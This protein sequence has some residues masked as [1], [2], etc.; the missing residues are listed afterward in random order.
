MTTT[1]VLF[2]GGSGSVGRQAV[3]WFRQRYPT[4]PVLVGGRD[5]RAAAEVAR[6]AGAAE[7]VVIDLSHP[8]MGLG[9]D[10]SVAAVVMLAP[11]AQLKA[12]RY[13]LD[14][15]I[16]YLDCNT[17]VVEMGPAVALSAHH[18]TAAPVVLNSH[19]AGGAALFLAL[20]SAA[21]FDTVRS[22][23][24][25]VVLDDEEPVGPLALDDMQR[26]GRIAA[27]LVIKESR[28]AWLSGDAA[29]SEVEAVDGRHL[30]AE[31]FSSMDIISLY[32][33]TGASGVRFDLASAESSSRRRGD[34]LAAE[35]VVDIEGEMGGSPKRSRSTLE[36]THGQVSLTALSLVLVLSATLGLH[37][38]PPAPPGLHLPE[39]LS[40]AEWFLGQLR[41][42][43]AVIHEESR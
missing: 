34:G 40:D 11:D 33:A 18:A 15:G 5:L 6:E 24:V 10:I 28:R 22:I 9:G 1:P 20:H 42:A 35:I 39:M 31:G 37:E 13:A 32:A 3:R 17:G 12:L 2:A 21:A 16:P 8:R 41:S 36:F 30:G 27:I 38:R 14:S 26:L 29:R 23:K 4:I 43:G 19:W 7:G 25:G